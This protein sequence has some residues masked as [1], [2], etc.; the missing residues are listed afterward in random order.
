MVRIYRFAAVRPARD[1]ASAIAAVPYDVVTAD[2]VREILKKNPE[3]FLRVSRPDAELPDLPPDDDRVYLRARENFL[4]LLKN[5]RMVRDPTPGLYLYRVTQDGETF[6]GLAC[7]LDVEDYRAN[8]IRRHEQTR[9]DKEEDRTRHIRVTQTHNGP[10]VLLY[11]DDTDL[12]HFIESIVPTGTAPDEEVHAGNGTVHQVF[13]ISDPKVM[14][15]IEQ[16]FSRVPNLYIAD[17]HHRA[18]S[19][20]NV[21][22]RYGGGGEI[23]RFLGVLFAHDRVRIHGYS[24]LI[25]DTGTYTPASF[26]EGLKAFFTVEPY[27][28]V[29]GNGFQIAPKI[30][31]PDRYHVVHVYTE[32]QWYECTRPIDPGLTGPESLD[33]AVLQRYVLEGMLGITD[34]RGDA[35]LQYLGG[36]RPV[37]D[38][39]ELVDAGTYRVAIA[40]QPVRVDTVLAIADAGGVMPPKSTWFEP[41][42]LSGL[43]VHTFD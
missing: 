30:K 18:K 15:T 43:L 7:C 14:D 23:S 36:A 39:M 25:T 41:K 32:G 34:P 24:R 40:M 19:A 6:L 17:G 10:V 21:A 33:V 35:R 8:H 42:L 27:N 31:D 4:A 26:I 3:S 1:A 20:V 2:E 12:C 5:G 11:E 13:R 9:Y 29:D 22:E 28:H 37:R 38:L 16:R